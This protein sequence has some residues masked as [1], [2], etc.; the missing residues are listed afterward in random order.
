M[1]RQRK[2]TAPVLS[3]TLDDRSVRWAPEGSHPSQVSGL[4]KHDPTFP[5]FR[6]ILQ[7]QRQEDYQQACEA[8]VVILRQKGEG[9]SVSSVRSCSMLGLANNKNL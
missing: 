8:P 9:D 1:P 4:L 5:E 2:S 3:R 6:K 7:R